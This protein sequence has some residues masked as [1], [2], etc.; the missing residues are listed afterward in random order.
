MT[1]LTGAR[2]TG[3]TTLVRHLLPKLKEQESLYLNFD[4]PDERLRVAREPV[5]VLDRGYRRVVIDEVQK[6]PGVLDAVK[7]IADRGTNTRFV[8]LGSAQILLLK[9]VQ[10]TLAGRAALLELWPLS[11]GERA[12]SGGPWLMDA[13][14][15]NGE[16]SLRFVLFEAA[17]RQPFP[18]F[19]KRRE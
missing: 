3:K 19:T 10:E 14:I 17:G 9:Q 1:V 11:V 15:E 16:E 2:Q 5:G 18:H 7:L 4:D 8:L 13:I 12:P 6:L